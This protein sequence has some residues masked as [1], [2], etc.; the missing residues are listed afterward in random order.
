MRKF[1]LVLLLALAVAVAAQQKHASTSHPAATALKPASSEASAGLPAEDDV[2]GFL[3]ETFGYNPQLTWKIVSIKPAE[4]KGLAEVNVQISSPEG[5]GGQ[6]F[7]VTQDGKHAVV[8]DII[9]FGKHP[10]TATRLELQKKANGPAKGPANAPVMVVEFSDLQCPHCKEAGPTVERLL[11]ENPNV[12]FVSQNFPLPNHNWA[13]K[14]AAYADCVGHASNDAYWKFIDG[15]FAIQEQ[16]TADNADDKL[17]GVADASGVKGVDMGL[18]AAKP[19]TQAKVEASINL[20]KALGVNS[21]PTLFINGRLV[22]VAGNNYDAL[23]Q[24]V[25]FAATDKDK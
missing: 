20:G 18:C 8:G 25:D 9:P 22:G 15:V 6:R 4:A 19:E 7:F 14:A 5:Q 11:H 23:K 16:I 3:H 12:R 13:A 17:T 21:T 2:N 24:L 10:F 1:L